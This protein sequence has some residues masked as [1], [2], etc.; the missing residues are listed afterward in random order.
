VKSVVKNSNENKRKGMNNKFDELAKG[1]AQSVT[2][3]EAFKR[4]GLGLAGMA[5]ACFGLANKANAFG[6][7]ERN[8][9]P[10][11][12]NSDCN[13]NEVCTFGACE[14][15]PCSLSSDCG[16]NQICWFGHCILY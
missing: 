3:R 15:K 6:V 5:L 16:K 13:Q 11:S 14:P 12:T 7:R 8:R 4:F 10:C 9:K 1:F 2:R